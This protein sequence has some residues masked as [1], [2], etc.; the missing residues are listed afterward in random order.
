MSD[1]PMVAFLSAL[2]PGQGVPSL[3][4]IF[5]AGERITETDPATVPAGTQVQRV[6]VLGAVTLA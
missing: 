3:P 2:G 1:R 6:A 5:Q 4:A